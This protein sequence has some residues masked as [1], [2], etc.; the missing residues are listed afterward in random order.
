MKE[1]L[2]LRIPKI[3]TK[4]FVNISVRNLRNIW[5]FYMYVYV[6]VY[7]S[8]YIYRYIYIHTHK[9]MQSAIQC[10]DLLLKMKIKNVFINSVI[11]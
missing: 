11:L 8:I 4:I 2:E 5:E 10:H 7:I 1:H 6:S 3:M 9:N